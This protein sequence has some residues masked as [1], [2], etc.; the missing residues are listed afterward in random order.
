MD[1][2][3]TTLSDVTRLISEVLRQHYG[4]DPEPLL[5][6][7][8]IESRLADVSGSRVL[9]ESMLK[10]WELAAAA[11]N[12]PSVGLV[13]GSKVRATTFYA[14]GVAFITSEKLADALELLC[15]YYRVIAT[16]PLELNIKAG[17][18][19][20]SL[21]ITYTDSAYPLGSIPFD[22]FIASIV[23]LCRLA[24]SPEFNPVEVRLACADNHR[25]GDYQALFQAPVIFSAK[26]NALVFA[27]AELGKP[28]PGRSLD[29]LYASDRVL[30]NYIAALNPDE[31]ST[32]VRKLLLNML[33]KGNVNQEIISKR[34]NVSRST[35]HRRL[36]DENTNYK[37]LLDSTR[38]SLAVEY[39]RESEYALGYIAFLLGFS[40]QS[41]FSRAFRRWTGQSPKAYREPPATAASSSMTN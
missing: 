8:G 1:V 29:M 26:K 21:E 30:E 2:E 15:R 22:S 19:Q 25:A 10:L 39:V 32:E 36:R 23:G 35:L 12:D 6:K 14:L 7:A 3:P 18:K 5:E 13:V 4:V 27:T 34:M 31:V 40:D 9:R 41:N 24:T 38:H 20:S 37:E 28:L 33:P 17:A 16:V 11:T